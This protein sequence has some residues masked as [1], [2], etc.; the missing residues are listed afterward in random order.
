V[1]VPILAGLLLL[2][3][4]AAPMAAQELTVRFDPDA[5][6]V[7]F[8]VGAT[9]HDVHGSFAFR[10][11]EI[12]LDPR[13]GAASGD[14]VVDATG[15]ETGNGSR[16][17]TMH[18]KVLESVRFPLFVFHTDEVVGELA[19]EGESTLELRGRLEIHGAEHPVSIPATVV[20]TGERFRSSAQFMV[21]YEDWG[22]HNPGFLFLRVAPEVQVT[23]AAEGSLEPADEM[24]S[25]TGGAHGGGR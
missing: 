6:E 15:G 22:M 13:T 17:K 4:A 7:T 11:G 25:A 1:L 10:E 20:R 12:R 21:P 16:D 19:P 8:D 5:T 3:L 2:F 24:A 18:K 23:V 9:G 14:L